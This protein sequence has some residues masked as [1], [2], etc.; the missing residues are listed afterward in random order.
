MKLK[1]MI[2]DNEYNQAFPFDAEY[3]DWVN[4]I[5]YEYNESDNVPA[6]TVNNKTNILLYKDNTEEYSPYGTVNSQ[7]LVVHKFPKC[8][9]VCIVINKEQL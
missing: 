3:T 9:N 4:S 8:Y 1:N 6:L 5:D 2:I 7:F